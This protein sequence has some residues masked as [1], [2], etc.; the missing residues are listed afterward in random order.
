MSNRGLC[1]LQMNLQFVGLDKGQQSQHLR[2]Y[3]Q[4]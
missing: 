3:Q 1:T 4:L 2:G